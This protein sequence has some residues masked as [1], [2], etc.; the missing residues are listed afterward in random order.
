MGNWLL[1]NKLSVFF[2]LK[3]YV[4]LLNFELLIYSAFIK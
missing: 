4:A 3:I 1:F 2:T